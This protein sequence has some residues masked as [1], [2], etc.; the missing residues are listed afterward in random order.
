M[1]IL[2]SI[3]KTT[4][5]TIISIP[6]WVAAV[7]AAREGFSEL[8]QLIAFADVFGGGRLRSFVTKLLSQMELCLNMNGLVGL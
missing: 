8:K 1:Y 4:P 3:K 7:A 2:S 5:N 6:L